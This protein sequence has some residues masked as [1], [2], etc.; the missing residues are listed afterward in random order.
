MA[1]TNKRVSYGAVKTHEGAIAS[2]VSKK[3]ELKRAVLATLLW[4]NGFYEEGESIADRIYKLTQSVKPEEAKDIL[5]EAKMKQKLRHTPLLMLVAMTE[6]GWVTKNMV[7]DVL[8]RVDDIP[9]LLSLYWKNGKKP[10]SKQL[11]KGIDLALRKYQEYQFAKYDR[12]KAIKLR[13]VFRI[14]R[15]KPSTPRQA[16]LWGK[17][18]KGTLTPPDT[19]EVS[20]SQG[21]D[22]KETFTRLIKEGKL[23]DL[24]FIRNLRK[25]QEVGVDRAIIQESMKNRKWEWM[26]PYQFITAAKYNPQIEED[27]EKA[28]LSCL[29]GI[30]KIGFST[31]LL[32]DVSA[33]MQSKISD[34]SEANRID[35][36]AGLA[37]IARE[38][39]SNI[40]IFS[41]E[42]SSKRIPNRHGFALRDA[43]PA[44]GT[45]TNMWTAIRK[46]GEEKH[47]ELMIVITDEQTQDVGKISDANADLLVIINVAN[48]QNG[49]GY[50]KGS[51]HISGWS[52]NVL[53]Y[54]Q[55]YIKLNKINSVK[56]SDADET[57]I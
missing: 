24:A 3:E 32:V 35:V 28:M 16:D 10:L 1:S 22:K 57:N 37:I 17:V 54:V 38:I 47:R 23:G 30:E 49:V 27:I 52:E 5:L 43:L 20:L 42:V 25:M 12:P 45:G 51:I 9:E 4:E 55:E 13:D 56:R 15:P 33:S 2:R 48:N 29:S 44:D 26:L 14:I 31:A 50:G 39:F 36:A 8:T 41:F 11:K 19:W 7:S 46:V 34:K 40:D 21:K 18:V 53:N 6:K